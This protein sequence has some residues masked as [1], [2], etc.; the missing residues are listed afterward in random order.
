MPPSSGQ[1]EPKPPF[2]PQSAQ[3]RNARTILEDGETAPSRATNLADLA[4]ATTDSEFYS[5][6]PEGYQRGHHK[7]VIVLGTVM[8]GLGKGIFSSS[9]AKMLKEKGLSP[10]QGLLH[11]I[12]TDERFSSCCVSKIQPENKLDRISIGSRPSRKLSIGPRAP[13][14]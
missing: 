9:L 5:P 11:A 1:S 14:G 2:Q 13:G 10:Y 6:I 3:R 12:W 8:S 7:Y 4:E